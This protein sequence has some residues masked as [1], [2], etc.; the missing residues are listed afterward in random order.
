M[1]IKIIALLILSF[2]YF[3]QFAN[4]QNV[5]SL[6]YK[7]DS[8]IFRIT[9]Q[10]PEFINGEAAMLNFIKAKLI[11]PKTAKEKGTEGIIIAQFIVRFDG[12]ITD[13]KIL[14]DIGDGCGNAVKDV[15]SKM[16]DWKCGKQ[17]GKPVSV[18]YTIPVSFSLK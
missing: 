18:Y 12:K 10:M 11:Y 1:R 7:N 4:A 15:I 3:S 17:N 5:D 6:K 9:E 13:I 8:M 2:T 14:R 16:P